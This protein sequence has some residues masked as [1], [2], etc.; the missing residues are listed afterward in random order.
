MRT[1]QAAAAV[2]FGLPRE[3]ALKAVTINAAR[4][5]GVDD[6]IGSLEVGKLAD[7]IVLDRNP[8]ED[9]HN[10]N[11]VRYTMVNGRLYDSLSMD[12]IAPPT[13]TTPSI[14][15][16]GFSHTVWSVKGASCSLA[17]P[18]MCASTSRSA[19]PRCAPGSRSKR[20]AP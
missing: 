15:P 5:W 16:H 3:E 10:T 2:A 7:L 4:I 17:H 19:P 8:L 12:E 9:I 13:R 14:L 20:A 1:Y 11:S 6:Q 18:A